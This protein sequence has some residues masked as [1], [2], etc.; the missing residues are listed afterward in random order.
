MSVTIGTIPH[1]PDYTFGDIEFHVLNNTNTSLTLNTT[2]SIFGFAVSGMTGTNS[3]G[4]GVGSFTGTNLRNRQYSLNQTNDIVLYDGSRSILRSVG[5]TGTFNLQARFPSLANLNSRHTPSSTLVLYMVPLNTIGD[6]GNNRIFIDGV[7]W[8]NSTKITFLGERA[9]LSY[10]HIGNFNSSISIDPNYIVKAFLVDKQ[11]DGTAGKVFSAYIPHLTYMLSGD[12]INLFTDSQLPITIT[13]LGGGTPGGIARNSSLPVENYTINGNDVFLGSDGA[14]GNRGGG[15]DGGALGGNGGTGG[16]SVG[17]IDIGTTGSNGLGYGGGMGLGP[18]ESRIQTY[19]IPERT[20]Q[21]P[22]PGLPPIVVPASDRS[23]VLGAIGGAGGGGGFD[24]EGYANIPN[25]NSQ[26]NGNSCLLL[27]LSPPVRNGDGEV[28][29]NDGLGFLGPFTTRS[30][31]RN[32]YIVNNSVSLSF[33][34]TRQITC[35]Y[36]GAGGQ[37]GKSSIQG[38]ALNSNGWTSYFHAGI[39]YVNNRNRDGNNR[40]N[41]WLCAGGAGAAG[42][43]GGGAGAVGKI[44]I[45]GTK[46]L[47]CNISSTGTEVFTEDKYLGIAT[48]GSNGT[49]S[50]Y[51]FEMDGRINGNNPPIYRGGSSTLNKPPFYVGPNDGFNTLASGTPGQPGS[52]GVVLNS[53][54]GTI[55]IRSSAGTYGGNGG[56]GESQ[57]FVAE[58][59]GGSPFLVEDDAE[60]GST[61]TRNRGPG[62]DIRIENVVRGGERGDSDMFLPKWDRFYDLYQ[63]ANPRFTGSRPAR[64]EYGK[65][66]EQGLRGLGFGAGNGGEGGNGGDGTTSFVSG[67]TGDIRLLEGIELSSTNNFYLVGAAGG[68]GGAGGFGGDGFSLNNELGQDDV[69]YDSARDSSGYVIIVVG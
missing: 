63:S 44:N 12:R 50:I 58:T 69:A 36:I 68:G 26:A 61:I 7:S 32:I 54:T 9:G 41:L 21:N 16:T 25:L 14:S 59:V 60:S 8:N 45:T 31:S 39:R 1:I 46:Y 4:Y 34:T 28:S 29:R 42:G 47:H 49:D 5:G 13:Q 30:R 10:F 57:G 33:N 11:K 18:T 62:Y 23:V 51:T 66:G 19:R 52:N 27:A 40:P 53:Y 22:I 56:R 15:P 17:T 55:I 38:T 43:G 2:K 37:G 24:L 67:S 6:Y 65:K 48:A 3:V 20:V 64:S 35:Y